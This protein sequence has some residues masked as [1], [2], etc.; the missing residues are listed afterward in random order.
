M[1]VDKPFTLSLQDARAV[2][3]TADRCRRIVSVFQN[4]RWD[5][6]YLGIKRVIDDGLIGGL[7]TSNPTST[8]SAPTRDRWRENPARVQDCGS[9][10]APPGRSGPATVRPAR[11]GL[12][13]SPACVRDLA[14]MTG[15][16]SSLDYPRRRVVLHASMLAA[17]RAPVRRARHCRHSGQ[18]R[19]RHSGGSTQGRCLTRCRAGARIPKSLS[20]MPPVAG[21]ASRRR[22]ETNCSTTE[23][24]PG[25]S[26]GT[27]PIHTPQGDSR[28]DGRRRRRP[29]GSADGAPRRTLP[30][31]KTSG[32]IG[33]N[34]RGESPQPLQGNNLSISRAIRVRPRH[35]GSRPGME[36]VAG[37]GTPGGLEP[38][39]DRW[40]PEPGSQSQ[41]AA[42]KSRAPG[43]QYQRSG[44]GSAKQLHRRKRGEQYSS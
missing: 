20:T 24:W 31:P 32:R 39:A 34:D 16:M 6:D 3:A 17:A 15:R 13:T 28:R 22:P 25:R 40:R 30:C 33:I 8:G 9:T 26:P 2:L 1:A 10:S 4:R 12:P 11:R 19:Q 23:N 21:T 37:D 43:A 7:S 38:G 42:L 27:A 36:T 14:P 44:C 41:S 29:G 35:M 18:A 5:S